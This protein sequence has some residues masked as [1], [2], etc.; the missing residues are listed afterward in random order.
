MPNPLDDPDLY[1]YF[2][3]AGERS[4]GLCDVSGANAPRE[5]DI[6]KGYGLSGASVVYTGDGLAKFTIRLFFSETEHFNAWESFRRLIAKPPRGTR[7][8]A[9]DI[10]YP[11]LAEL[12]ITSAVVEDE[13]QWTQPEPGLF[14]KDIKFIQFRAPLPMLAKPDGSQSRSNEPTAQTE[15]DRT[16]EALTKQLKELAA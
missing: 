4:P 1:D 10:G 11:F 9:Q 13:L 7:P 15:A 5:W 8:K 3:L 16:I 6:R 12:G 2:T 14:A